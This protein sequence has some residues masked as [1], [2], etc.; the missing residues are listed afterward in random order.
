MAS[1]TSNFRQGGLEDA[2][3]EQASDPDDQVAPG[4]QTLTRYLTGPQ[5]GGHALPQSITGTL[6]P[7][8]G[9]LDDV[10]VHDDAKASSMVRSMGAAAFTYGRNIYSDG[11]NTDTLAHE[12]AHAAQHRGPAPT[13]PVQFGGD[14]SHEA[15][16]DQAA[17]A[18]YAPSMQLAVPTAAPRVRLRENN[19][20]DADVIGALVAAINKDKG[21]AGQMLRDAADA[22]AR[23][24]IEA[25]VKQ[26]FPEKDDAKDLIEKN[27]MAG[28]P[29][30]AIKGADEAQNQGKGGDGKLVPTG[31]K[32]D[33][34][35]VKGAPG[36][37]AVKGAAPHIPESGD[38]DF[39][40]PPTPPDPALA[41]T[42]N[43]GLGLIQTELT[44]HEKWKGEIES[45]RE[46]THVGDAGSED[47]AAF[48][49]D[50]AGKGVATGAATGVATAVA[51]KAVTMGLEWG[52]TK[53]IGTKIPGLGAV[54]A[55]GM[56]AYSLATKNWKESG[57]KIAAMGTGSD[58]Y[59]TM[60]NTLAG[61]GEIL[62][63]AINI[64][65]VIAGVIAIAA[66]IMWLVTILTL[67]VASPLAA[68]FTAIAAGIVAVTTILDAINRGAIQPLVMLFRV[69][70][71][72]TTKAD[73]R[74]VAEQGD[75]IG[76][77]ASDA[78]SFFAAKAAEAG[79]DKAG[80]K[81]GKD[82]APELGD[83]KKSTGGEGSEAAHGEG[84]GGTDKAHA[85]EHEHVKTEEKKAPSAE[86]DPKKKPEGEGKGEDEHAK[87]KTKE[88]KKAE[89][90]QK[91]AAEEAKTK[92]EQEQAKKQVEAA[93][94]AK[95]DIEAKSEKNA[96][97]RDK[98]SETRDEKVTE[99]REKAAEEAKEKYQAEAEAKHAEIDQKL[100]EKLGE[101]DT[102]AKADGERMDAANKARE[103]AAHEAATTE[104][105]AT[106]KAADAKCAADKSAAEGRRDAAKAASAD[107]VA[108]AGSDEPAKFKADADKLEAKHAAASK[109]VSAITDEKL[110][111]D[112]QADQDRSYNEA[113]TELASQKA[114]AKAEAIKSAQA[115]QAKVDAKADAQYAKE[116]A[117]ADAR[118]ENA[119]AKAKIL[120]DKQIAAA[121]TESGKQ[122]VAHEE[123][124][125]ADKEAAGAEA[126]HANAA[127]DKLAADKTKAAG[128]EAASVE[129]DKI[130][131]ERAKLREEGR[132]LQRESAEAEEKEGKLKTKLADEGLYE[133]TRGDK[134]AD[135]KEKGGSDV[136][137][138]II[139]NPLEKAY[140]KPAAE[141]IGMTKGEEKKEE[142]KPNEPTTFAGKAGKAVTDSASVLSPSADAKRYHE[143]REGMKEGP[144][145]ARVML[146]DPPGTTEQ[147]EG[148]KTKIAQD[149]KARAAYDKSEQHNKK[150]EEQERANAAKLK[151]AKAANTDV[152]AIQK[153]HL[154]KVDEKGVAVAAQKEKN[155]E[156][157]RTI[158]ERSQRMAGVTAVTVP[159]A[160]FTGLMWVGAKLPGSWGAK[161]QGMYNDGQNLL[162]QFGSITAKMGAAKAKTDAN[163]VKLDGDKAKVADT[164][165][166]SEKAGTTIKGTGDKI[167]D[168]D[169][170]VSTNASVASEEK[171]KAGTQKGA[172]DASAKK[173]EAD[174]AK[175]MGELTAW[176][177]KHKAARLGG[178]KKEGAPG[179]E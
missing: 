15:F 103:V 125:E 58:D 16:A 23:G 57:A 25:A 30:P 113:K 175:M 178:E 55:G 70:H 139:K 173:G 140:A 164:Q 73:P 50:A 45:A 84:K 28:K 24:K 97:A 159:L 65:N 59:E 98:L 36:G 121:Q 109:E 179:G 33:K 110:R 94:K 77:A 53:L 48:V 13:G 145:K 161:F 146:P 129:S 27:P 132:K 10:R 85:G 95:K 117:K 116:S 78:A 76:E 11:A 174:Y 144:K 22:D 92:A 83:T 26:A 91:R 163:D 155:T 6:G 158:V 156:G 128:D 141:A 88:E 81:L 170:K 105:V 104:Q 126:E 4:R 21:K 102:K 5:D 18:R 131:K 115:E 34:P 90:E 150:T 14:A 165:K 148:I 111:T 37:G 118:A 122:V 46:E 35:A 119:K 133:K 80:E 49:A 74:D 31:D 166:K 106:A 138:S 47:R 172:A 143:L 52:A 100:K 32:A 62:D 69:M 79:M 149:M 151:G 101:I 75:G 56:S 43:E 168:M 61:I 99:A 38:P 63:I 71:T 114:A 87:E 68:T 39:I 19:V 42:S 112:A 66:G 82:D 64:M 107:K 3:R 124:L 20:S 54:L 134:W 120:A 135:A 8:L 152:A 176:A 167:S 142:P 153:E 169:A 9:G 44:E 51:G 17:A 89:E 123:K 160:A 137:L 41:A 40:G 136:D 157:K 86:E 130:L 96:E 29:A 67:G 127:A 12:A 93:E 162:K 1:S 60:A 177:Q 154:A 7:R 171:T 108:K 72:F 2:G 147:L